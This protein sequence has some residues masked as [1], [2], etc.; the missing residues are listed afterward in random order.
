[1]QY[2]LSKLSLALG[3]ALIS[4]GV[5]AQ[6]MDPSTW[7]PS[8][9]PGGLSSTVVD[10]AL[11]DAYSF[12][13][14]KLDGFGAREREVTLSGLS[15]GA[16]FAVQ[17]H[18][19]YAEI[20]DGSAAIAGGAYWCSKASTSVATSECMKG[21]VPARVSLDRYY[22]EEKRGAIASRD[23]LRGDRGFVFS[24]ENDILVDRATVHGLENFYV[25]LLGSDHVSSEYNSPAGHGMPTLSYGKPC[26]RRHYFNS[27]WLLNCDLDGAG[28]ILEALLDDLENPYENF[29]DDNYDDKKDVSDLAGGSLYTFDQR[30]FIEES[31]SSLAD[32][33]HVFIPT[34]CETRGRNCRIHVA[35]HGCDQD[36]MTVGSAFIIKGGYNQ[37]ASA[38]DLIILYPAA[39][40]SYWA[41]QNPLGC[42]DW[43]GYTG[44]DFHLR[45]GVQM[46][47]VR[48]MI[49]ALAKR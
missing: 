38:N 37:W 8:V 44:E 13:Q 23:H 49:H 12:D 33:G 26:L 5:C 10:R 21:K 2:R 48:A 27:P 24:G 7:W 22:F 47:A 39:A 32:Y 19:A 3:L 42:F 41:P 25:E 28:M 6:M 30:P 4:H 45:S 18:M 31:G 9:G 43:W 16:F 36:P 40:K 46:K 20:A 29:Y 1:M 17:F 34:Q 11:P 35:L 14:I 15:A